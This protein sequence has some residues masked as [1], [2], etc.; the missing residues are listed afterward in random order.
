[1]NDPLTDWHVLIP[2][3]VPYENFVFHT[4]TSL[5]EAFPLPPIDGSKTTVTIES[6]AHTGVAKIGVK[7]V[8]IQKQAKYNDFFIIKTPQISD[9]YIMNKTYVFD[10]V[11]KLKNEN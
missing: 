5:L 6:F 4:P 10:I 8:K 2:V 9:T 1:M 3:T 7:N 11:V